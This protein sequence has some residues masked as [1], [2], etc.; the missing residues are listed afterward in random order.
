M[1]GPLQVSTDKLTV[2]LFFRTVGT[3]KDKKYMKNKNI[4]YL[5]TYLRNKRADYR[6]VA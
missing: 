5:V 1:D 4:S 3:Q 2:R 6:L